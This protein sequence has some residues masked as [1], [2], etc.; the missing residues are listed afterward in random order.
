MLVAISN[1]NTTI[2]ATDYLKYFD[3]PDIT[4]KQFKAAINNNARVTC[5]HTLS[6]IPKVRTHLPSFKLILNTNS[7]PTSNE[8]SYLTY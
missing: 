7:L 3:H 8:G 2:N 6:K 4:L 1:Y 5:V